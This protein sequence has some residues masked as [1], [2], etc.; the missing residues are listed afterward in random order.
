MATESKTTES[1]NSPVNTPGSGGTSS[2]PEAKAN[3][4]LTED[5]PQPPGV[6]TRRAGRRSNRKKRKGPFVKFVGQSS[7]RT[8]TYGDWKS[9]N[10]KIKGEDAENGVRPQHEWDIKNDFLVEVSQFSDEQ[11]D[12]LLIDD[13]QPGGGHSFL[14]VDYDPE[15]GD[16]L[17]VIYEEVEA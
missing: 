12:Y 16:L 15:T 11:L 5:M 8:I 17:Q 4:V 6:L 7:Q 10:I 13:T 3:D 9:L 14:E 1:T 2:A